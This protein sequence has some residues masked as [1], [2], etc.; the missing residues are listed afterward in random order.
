M[1]HSVEVCLAV[2]IILFRRNEDLIIASERTSSSFLHAYM[3]S[4]KT[5]K[6][7]K[8][9]LLETSDKNQYSYFYILN[10]FLKEAKK[11]FAQ[12]LNATHLLVY[13]KT[14]ETPC[15]HIYVSDV[16]NIRIRKENKRGCIC[17]KNI[18]IKKI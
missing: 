2:L 8:N 15:I 6:I 1:N 7:L 12:L 9:G 4:S 3:E 13:A 16:S 18:I 11:K 14:Y 10:S 17:L 5:H